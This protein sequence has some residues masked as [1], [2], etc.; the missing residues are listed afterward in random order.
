MHLNTIPTQSEFTK[1]PKNE[2]AVL[3]LNELLELLSKKSLSA[4]LVER[5]N[6]L[7]HEIVIF[8]GTDT[9][10]YYL[11]K[12]Q[13]TQ[14]VSLLEKK[15]KWV[16]KNYYRNLWMILGMTTFGLPLGVVFGLSLKNMAFLGIGLPIGLAFGIALGNHLD[17]KAKD[18]DRQLDIEL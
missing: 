12:K 2:K 15:L 3:K 11:V 5:I 16:P 14:I 1:I 10:F 7:T 8:S 13:Q 6:T 17:Q 9:R 4:E 18:E